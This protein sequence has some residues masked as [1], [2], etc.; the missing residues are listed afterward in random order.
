MFELVALV[1][2]SPSVSESTVTPI[3]LSLSQSHDSQIAATVVSLFVLSDMLWH[4]CGPGRMAAERYALLASCDYTLQ[5]SRPG[6]TSI[7]RAHGHT[8]KI[9]KDKRA[10]NASECQAHRKHHPIKVS[11]SIAELGGRHFW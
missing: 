4:G 7:R 11:G 10:E 6:H 2:N 9:C 5:P 3:Q 8:A 1:R